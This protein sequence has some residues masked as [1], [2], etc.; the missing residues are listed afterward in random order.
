MGKRSDTSRQPDYSVVMGCDCVDA[1]PLESWVPPGE[2]WILWI[3]VEIG[4]GARGDL[5]TACI[6]TPRAIGDAH[7]TLG[8]TGRDAVKGAFSFQEFHWP[9]IRA[10][11]EK[12]VAAAQNAPGESPLDFLR[13]RLAW[14][15]EG[16][17]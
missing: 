12:L 8:G 6:G 11:F 10:E 14:E 3:T 9:T 15:Y 4:D 5:F 2:D 13:H 17:S 1:D 16:M 7:R